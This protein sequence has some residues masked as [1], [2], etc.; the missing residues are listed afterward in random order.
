MVGKKKKCLVV[1][2]GFFCPWLPV[3]KKGCTVFFREPSANI[4]HQNLCFSS[5]L[6]QFLDSITPVAF[7]QW[8]FEMSFVPVA[9]RAFA[10]FQV[11]VCRVRWTEQALLRLCLIE[12]L[13]PVKA[14]HL[15]CFIPQLE[16]LYSPSDVG[17]PR[18]VWQEQGSLADLCQKSLKSLL[19]SLSPQQHPAPSLCRSVLIFASKCVSCD[20]SLPT[21]HSCL[22]PQSDSTKSQLRLLINFSACLARHNK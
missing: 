13:I 22:T 3:D 20:F 6:S 12:V 5:H 9:L 7:P 21:S 19:S 14:H 17:P 16:F 2:I 4:P 10:H 8:R 18:E 15:T 11:A 1:N